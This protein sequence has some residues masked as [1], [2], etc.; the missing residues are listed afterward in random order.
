MRKKSI[1]AKPNIYTLERFPFTFYSKVFNK[2]IKFLTV[3]FD[4]GLEGLFLEEN[5]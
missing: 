2:D 5:L 1:M 4:A 3:V